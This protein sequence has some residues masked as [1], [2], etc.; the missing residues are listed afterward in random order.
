[1]QLVLQPCGGAEA[2]AHFEDTIENLVP[3]TR[4]LPYL[5]AADRDLVRS[6]FA[7]RV[8]VWGVTPA[9]N[10]SNAAK[11][12]KMRIGDIALMYRHGRFFLKA[13]VGFKVHSMELAL[14][15]W[16]KKADGLTW[17]HIFFLA[18]LKPIDIP[19][20]RFN[21]AANYKPNFVVQGYQVLPEDR[22]KRICSTLD[23]E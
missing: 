20:D 23:L 5:S 12:R 11:W 10:G 22:S 6:R 16:S 3:L 14:D 18:D 13:N 17:E 2:A 7:D 21:L 19:I 1:M 4:I 8:A 9:K 15:L